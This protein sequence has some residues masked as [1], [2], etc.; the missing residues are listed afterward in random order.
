[1]PDPR[2]TAAVIV[3]GCR[4]RSERVLRALAA[5]SVAASLEVVVVDVGTAEL[6]ALESPPGPRLVYLRAPGLVWSAG[7]ARAVREAS[8]PIVAFIEDHC[9]PAPDW[10]ERLLEAH[11][12][13]W[14]AVG[15]AFTNANP[16]S[17]W[18]RACLMTDYG[19]WQHPARHGPCRRLPGQN[20]SYKRELLL[21]LG[22]R[23]EGLLTPDFNLLEEL[24]RAGHALFVESRA[25]AAHQNFSAPAALLSAHRA[26]TRL[27][28]ARRA[29]LGGWSR[30]R[31][32][33]YGLAVLPGAPLVNTLRTA[34]D[35]RR[36][37]PLPLA[38][39]A[40]LPVLLATRC[41]AAL[42]E[43]CGYLF[44]E[45]GAEQDLQRWELEIERV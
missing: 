3:G 13:P 30:S 22:D 36:R 26:Y 12:G 19:S 11:E 1:M 21:R 20:L 29:A 28:A 18:S 2:L 39:V 6:P 24:K 35:L 38:F 8:T 32:I 42:G 17:Y 16:E 45:G 40:S 37:W 27:F 4:R 44:G 9:F 43:S 25:R 31:R 15:Y 7:R 10:A 5:Q 23:L 41:W 34:L 33:F 14:A